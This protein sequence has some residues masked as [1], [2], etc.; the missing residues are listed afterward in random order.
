MHLFRLLK[1]EW[2]SILWVYCLKGSLFDQKNLDRIITIFCSLDCDSVLTYLG[3]RHLYNIGLH[4]SHPSSLS[5]KSIKTLWNWHSMTNFSS[6]W[7]N[8]HDSSSLLR[9]S[10]CIVR[11]VT[12]LLVTF[13]NFSQFQFMNSLTYLDD[14]LLI[15]EHPLWA[16]NR[17]E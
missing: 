16:K 3:T 13:L 2:C 14:E 4:R 6:T 1:I 11:N 12:F 10:K 15:F 5:F 9:I 8:D 17:Y 7:G